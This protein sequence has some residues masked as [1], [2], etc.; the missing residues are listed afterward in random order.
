MASVTILS[1]FWLFEFEEI[2]L[3]KTF[4]NGIEHHIDSFML[5]Y[6]ETKKSSDKEDLMEPHMHQ[7][8]SSEKWNLDTIFTCSMPNMY[9]R[10]AFITLFGR[11]ENT[12]N[13]L[14][15]KITRSNSLSIELHDMTG[16]GLDR[17]ILY[18]KKVAGLN[19]TSKY[20]LKIKDLQFIRNK[21]SHTDGYID[22]NS[23]KNFERILRNN[24]FIEEDNYIYLKNGF[25]TFTIETFDSF[26]KDIYES[27]IK[28]QT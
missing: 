8:L 19:V 15:E 4:A 6:Q 3:L 5:S 11:Y 21:I 20:W 24:P 25:L 22:I 9:R 28:I 27:N 1:I 14:C 2:E 23:K 16:K 10:S 7:E 17:A 13:R 26:L 12:L 18:L